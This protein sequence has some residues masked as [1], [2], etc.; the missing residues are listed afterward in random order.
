MNTPANNKTVFGSNNKPNFRFLS[1]TELNA[2][3][4]AD[5]TNNEAIKANIVNTMDSPR[6]WIIRDFLS[7]PMTF[8]IP[9]S[10]ERFID[11]AVERL[12]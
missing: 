1:I 8:F 11:L 10:L 4:A 9:T 12:M 5:T 3:N 7:A 6:E 2:G